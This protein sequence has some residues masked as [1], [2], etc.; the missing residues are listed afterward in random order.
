MGKKMCLLKL[1]RWDL[2]AKCCLWGCRHSL[3]SRTSASHWL[4]LSLEI[5][6]LCMQSSIFFLCKA[7]FVLFYVCGIFFHACKAPFFQGRLIREERESSHELFL[8]LT[9][10]L[11]STWL[12]INTAKTFY[13]YN[14]RSLLRMQIFLIWQHHWGFLE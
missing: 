14:F 7:P 3:L 10:S 9:P 12:Q 5:I 11:S 1:N 2:I 8:L 4:N 6:F 13:K